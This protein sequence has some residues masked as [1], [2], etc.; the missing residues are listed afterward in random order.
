MIYII[1]CNRRNFF[2]KIQKGHDDLIEMED[3]NCFVRIRF[4]M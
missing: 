1:I 3:W 2:Q 4:D